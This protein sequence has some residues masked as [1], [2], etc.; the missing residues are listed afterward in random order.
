MVKYF[1]HDLT[2]VKPIAYSRQ[3]NLNKNSVPVTKMGEG[4]HL[5]GDVIVINRELTE[6]DVF[7]KDFLEVLKNIAII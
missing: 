6:L 3:L 1:Q 2:S 5:E 7:V 4:Y